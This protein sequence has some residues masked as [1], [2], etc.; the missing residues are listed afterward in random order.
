MISFLRGWEEDTKN[1]ILSDFLGITRVT[2]DEREWS[3]NWKIWV[4]SFMNDP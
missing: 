1:G 4:T 3:K 2:K